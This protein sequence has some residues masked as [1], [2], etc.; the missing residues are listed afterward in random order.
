MHSDIHALF[1]AQ[2]ALAQYLPGFRVRTQ[3]IEMAQAIADAIRA[4]TCLITEAGTGT[5]KTFAYLVPALVSGGKIIISTG[6]KTLQ[7]QLFER[8][9][10]FVRDA[11]KLPIAV[12][13][14]KGRG[15]YICLHRLRQAKEIDLFASRQDAQYI[16]SILS[17]AETSKRGDRNE[18]S[19][20]PENATIWPLVTST[21]DNCLGT[22]C[23]YASDCFVT[24]ARKTALDADILVVNHH[25]FF[26]DALLREEGFAE[27]LPAC[28]TIILDEAHQLP[29]IATV[30]F[31]DRISSTQLFEFARDTEIAVRTEAADLAELLTYL[32]TLNSA[33]RR[34]RLAAGEFPGKY[35][36]AQLLERASFAEA[37][38][39]LIEA[40]GQIRT[41]LDLIAEHS[42]TLG[43]A[44]A[45]AEKLRLALNRWQQAVD[46][47]ENDNP[48]Q[49]AYIRWADISAYHWQLH[50]SPLSVASIF[51]NYVEQSESAWILTSATLAVAGD[52]SHFQREL[53]LESAR[54]AQWGS[55]FDFG[56]AARL[57]V[58]TNLPQPNSREHTEAVI[59]AALPLLKA[60]DGNAFFLFTSH[61]ALQYAQQC[62]SEIFSE[63]HYPWLLLAQGEASRSELLSRFR[64][65]G[66]AVLLGAASFWEGVD[67]AGDA[68]SLVIIDKLPFAPPDDPLVAARLDL[69]EKNGGKP[70]FDWQIPQ[71]AISLK[72]G[73]GRLIRTESDR[74]VLM[75][76]DP[77]LVEK[78]YGR[79]LW[80][81]LPPMQRTRQQEEVVRFLNKIN[82]EA[83]SAV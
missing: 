38:A 43:L 42:E 17:F 7:D 65:E 10:P 67:V 83:V 9:I 5:G 82:A 69:L 3:Q 48:D 81:S 57:Y 21:R 53:G 32:D 20:V 68:L 49:N 73:A 37:F 58:P 18:L 31:G 19:I 27:L 14:L 55:P 61:R 50:T 16:K 15:N 4:Q 72:Q 39:A 25:L 59:H 56:S 35:P 12:A 70:F 8:D 63:H 60:N 71:A 75:I 29:D 54:T 74:G 6:T 13:Q 33:V 52:F 1:S 34:I 66:N 23:A 80:Q 30:F 62:L 64:K 36:A 22:Q 47:N 28:N 44:C 46:K 76:G 78:P 26:A 45:N 40:I 41:G 2:G 24:Q 79:K 11:L 51:R 77:R